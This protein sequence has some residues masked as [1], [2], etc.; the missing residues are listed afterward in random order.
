[1]IDPVQINLIIPKSIEAL[2]FLLSIIITN[3]KYRGISLSKRPRLNT[4]LFLA[5]IGFLIYIT[6]DI[7]IFIIAPFSMTK[8]ITYGR[9][10]GYPT[11]YPSLIIANFL[12]DLAMGGLLLTIWNYLFAA[13]NI[14]WGSKFSDR[15]FMRKCVIIVILIFSTATIIGDR[16]QVEISDIGCHVRSYWYGISAVSSYLIIFLLIVISFILISSFH[17]TTKKINDSTYRK[18]IFLISLGI[19]FLAFGF[20]YWILIGIVGTIFAHWN[21]F[22][23][24][25]LPYYIGHA[26]WL[27]SSVLILMGF[28]LKSKPKQKVYLKIAS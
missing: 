28:R 11:L 19:I 13:F 6:L 9:Y 8:N 18:K 16:V 14:R 1:M 17:T 20:F 2:F 5:Q 12:R 26:I 7:F 4:N 23:G 25:Y 24:L 22:L 3:K 15:I 27:T 21:V 10:T